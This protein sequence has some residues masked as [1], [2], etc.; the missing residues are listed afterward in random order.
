LFYTYDVYLMRDRESSE[1]L[2]PVPLRAAMWVDTAPP[3]GV[4]IYGVR[5]ISASGVPS[6]VVPSDPIFIE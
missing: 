5:A 1:L 4:R 6:A 3:K 2:S